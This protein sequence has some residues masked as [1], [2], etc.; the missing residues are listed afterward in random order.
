MTTNNVVEAE[1]RFKKVTDM[2]CA[3][4]HPDGPQKAVSH[5]HD[6]GP[7]VCG[8]HYAR[9]RRAESEAKK[10]QEKAAIEAA[11]KEPAPTKQPGQNS[12]SRGTH[13]AYA[14]PAVE[15]TQAVG[16]W[17]ETAA[18][19]RHVSTEELMIEILSEYYNQTCPDYFKEDLE[20]K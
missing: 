1:A 18:K 9:M 14:L 17:I 8:T 19:I 11:L 12:R 7:A 5:F 15:L 6:N 13:V 16:I 3:G 10:G 4:T 2:V 20:R